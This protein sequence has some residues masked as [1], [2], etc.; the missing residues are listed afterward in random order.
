ME[1]TILNSKIC[2]KTCKMIN[3]KGSN[4]GVIYLLRW[5]VQKILKALSRFLIMINQYKKYMK[6]F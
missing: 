4:D 3:Q 2:L 6:I 1:N 5:L